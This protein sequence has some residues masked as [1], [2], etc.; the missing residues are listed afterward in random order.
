[1]YQGQPAIRFHLFLIILCLISGRGFV[2]FAQ[3][4]KNPFHAEEKPRMIPERIDTLVHDFVGSSSSGMVLNPNRPD[5]LTNRSHF[6][7]EES[8]PEIKLK[9]VENNLTIENLREDGILEIYNIMGS[10]VFNRRVK[11][12]TTEITLP[13]PR[14]YYIIKIGKFT[15]KIAIK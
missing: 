14:G 11:A 9:L 2:G 4:K 6:L 10:K 15:R 13:V 8:H 5:T 12:G 7:L 3:E 1:M